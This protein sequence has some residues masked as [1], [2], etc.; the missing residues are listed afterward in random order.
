MPTR[1][2]RKSDGLH[3]RHPRERTHTNTHKHKRTQSPRP[4][5]GRSIMAACTAGLLRVASML[6][7]IDESGG[8]GRGCSAAG[9]SRSRLS[10][11]MFHAMSTSTGIIARGAS[12]GQRLLTCSSHSKYE[13]VAAVSISTSPQSV[14]ACCHSQYKHVAAVSTSTS[15]QSV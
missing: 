8:G 4:W 11:R 1:H 14:Q 6:W 3:T 15:P 13:Y 10:T 12:A 2:T 7:R 9:R 5:L